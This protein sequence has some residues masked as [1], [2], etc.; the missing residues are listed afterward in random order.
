[1]SC[2]IYNLLYFV[3]VVFFFKRNGW[4]GD[5][6]KIQ[7]V[8]CCFSPLTRICDIFKATRLFL[9]LV[10]EVNAFSSNYGLNPSG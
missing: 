8:F 7:E 2:F 4:K 3:V 5:K 1:M 10:G 6:L 9:K